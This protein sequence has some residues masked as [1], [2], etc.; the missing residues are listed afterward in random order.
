MNYETKWQKYWIKNKC[1]MPKIE[2][3]KKTFFLTVPYPY[4]NSIL[5][6]G[7]GRTFTMA[8]I[9]ARF[10]RAKG[11]N[12]LYPMGFHVSGT[13]VLA[14]SD[15]ICRNDS[16][17]IEK[18]KESISDFVKDKNEQNKLINSFKDPK[19]IAK[20]FSSK[21]EDTFNSVGLSIDWSRQFTTG[22]KIYQKFIEWQF[23]HLHDLGVLV[24]GK[25]PILYSPNDKNAVGEDDIKDGDTDKVSIQEMNY[26]L[27]KC[28]A[29]DE[30][31][32]IATLRPDAIF[33]TTNLWLSTKIKLVKIKVNNQIWIV[34][35]D[36]LEK[37]EH[38]FDGVEVLEAVDAKKYIGKNVIVPIVNRS[39]IIAKADN[40]I[41]SRHG[42]GVVYS[43]P[44]GAP[45]DYIA[46]VEA[47]KEGRVSNDL[48]VINTVITKDKKGN[49]IKYS[50]S[51]PAE[52]KCNKFKI[53]N[54]NDSDFL[55]SAKQELYKEE[56]Y[57][58]VLNELCGEFNGIP[59]KFVKDKVSQKLSELNLGG[60]IYETSRRAITRAKN[61]II[62]AV[63]DEQ[64]FLDYSKPEVKQKAYDL[65]KNM[66]YLPSSLKNSQNGYLEWVKM[67]PCARKRGI[68]TPLPLDK[69]WVIESLSDSTIYQM[70]YLIVNNIIKNKIK[71]KQ[72]TIEFF[73]YIFLDKGN[74]TLIC[75]STKI[76]KKL[77]LEIKKEINYWKA[78]DMR[79]TN[80]PHMSNHL[81]FLIYHYALIFPEV[82]HI[83]NITVAGL[84]IRDGKKI[85]KSKGNGLPLIKVKDSFGVDL[86]RLYVAVGATYE[87]E[88]DFRDDELFQLK[89]KFEKLKELLLAS[90][91]NKSKQY[92]DFSQRN[93]WLISKFY[94][95]AKSYFEFMDSM[96]IR[97]AHINI[98]YDF[99]NDINYHERI[100][101]EKETIDVIRFILKDYLL[102]M[103]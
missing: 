100:C 2:K 36:A 42:T 90:V 44:A 62:V 43:S 21:I 80:P 94:S 10:H 65:L 47:K 76:D 101:G 31:F 63:L 11:E 95:H 53:K 61:E 46:L 16:K 29:S 8:D 59:I 87:A 96:R 45:H 55:E 6:I 5:H 9:I 102:C 3:S 18:V 7:H 38:Q 22:D 28:E 4:A 54:S 99:L 26:I 103:G 69:E 75:E 71:S 74:L 91:K 1:F 98:L 27:F 89:N 24:Q 97:D 41:D 12:V 84:L 92:S 32:V 20:F 79:Y 37:I 85:S 60:I 35:K 66:E 49:V 40:I 72:L 56:H 73:D 23:K 50:G 25:Y 57:G 48:N 78:V 82:H 51:C 19:E 83:K 52:D 13:P 33:G 58:G 86:F 68:G 30:H 77:I 64:W 70:F 15:G 17:E 34:A 67:R 81:S 93:K 39:V 88:M 14:V